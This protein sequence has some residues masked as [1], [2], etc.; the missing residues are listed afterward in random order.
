MVGVSL[1]CLE[2]LFQEFD[3]K[4]IFIVFPTTKSY[5]FVQFTDVALAMKALMQLNGTKPKNFPPG[6]PPITILYVNKG[7]LKYY[8]HKL[9]VCFDNQC[10]NN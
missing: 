6:N 2:E 3:P 7:K 8:S 10:P 1:E 4:C 5:S 9:I